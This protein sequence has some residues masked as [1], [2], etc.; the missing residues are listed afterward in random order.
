MFS[1]LIPTWNNLAHLKLCVDSIR[2]HS[3]YDHE[4]I[5][6]V[7][8]GRDGTLRWVQE[9][10]LRHT[11]SAQNVGVCL[12]VNLLAAQ[13]TRDWI[14]YLNDDMVCCPG[15]DAALWAAAQSVGGRPALLSSLL[16]EPRATNNPQVVA[17]PCGTGPENFDEARLLARYRTHL[18]ADQDGRLSQ[19]TLIQRKW[20]HAVGGYSI[21]FGPGMSSDDDLAMK[22][23]VI[24][25]RIFRQV[26]TSCLYHFSCHST[27]RVRKNRGGRTFVMKWGITQQ[28]FVRSYLGALAEDPRPPE[29][30]DAH[31]LG[32]PATTLLGGLRRLAYGLKTYPLGDLGAWEAQPVRHVRDTPETGSVP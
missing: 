8:E 10:G 1:I 32:L 16:I 3:H 31:G 20:W 13:A 18:R 2:R 29:P 14:L 4:V 24:G 27:A 22:L 25:C 26:G 19:P 23:W 7:N 21:E 6:H 11:Y 30:G 28:E 17:D 5:I 9:Q 15:W 12:S